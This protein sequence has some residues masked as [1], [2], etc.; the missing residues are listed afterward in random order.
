MRKLYTAFLGILLGVAGAFAETPEAVYLVGDFNFWTEPASDPD[1]IEMTNAGDGVFTYTLENSG[2]YLQFKIFSAKTGWGDPETYWGTDGEM[3]T[4]PIY[5]G[6]PIS[7]KLVQGYA[8][9]N[10]SILNSA[11]LTGPVTLT[12]DWNA[13]TLTAESDYAPALADEYYF[14]ING[15]ADTKYKLT[16]YSDENPAFYTGTWEVPAGELKG[17][18]A[19]A[20]GQKYGSVFT[21]DVYLWKNYSFET[22]LTEAETCENNPF[23]IDNWHGGTLTV[24]LDLAHRFLGVYSESQPELPS[25]LYVVT[26][27]A[28]DG[29]WKPADCPQYLELKRDEDNNPMGYFGTVTLPADGFNFKFGAEGLNGLI[30]TYGDPREIY[31]NIETYYALNGAADAPALKCSNWEGGELGLDVNFRMT[32]ARTTQAPQQPVKT[33]CAYLIGQPQGWDIKSDAMSLTSTDGGLHYFGNYEIAAGEA[34]FRFY[35]SLYDW[36][37]GSI[38]CQVG[39]IPL[40]FEMT[41]GRYT[42]HIVIGGKGSWNFPS[43]PGGMMYIHL[44]MENYTVELANYDFA[45]ADFVKAEGNI[46]KTFEGGICVERAETAL[47]VFDICGRRVAT[48][49]VGEAA[50]LPAGVYICDGKKLFVR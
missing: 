9:V 24:T 7:W 29:S 2:A 5:K 27:P 26:N 13:G 14:E 30:G 31:T 37:S 45:G 38:G 46:V 16:R 49:S 11:V 41:D 34:M 43:W 28:A 40:D 20:D 32:H 18:V 17:L 42:G 25:K 4:Q 33:I 48:L 15:E 50:S 44:N 3:A 1:P 39:D 21:D 47:D 8:G 22:T 35:T 10:F 36:D 6:L 19:S 12:L 23:S